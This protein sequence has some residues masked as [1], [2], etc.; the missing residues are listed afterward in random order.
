[1]RASVPCPHCGAL[2]PVGKRLCKACGRAMDA[3]VIEADVKQADKVK[4]DVSDV[5]RA[6]RYAAP[7]IAL[8]AVAVIAIGAGGYAVY[9][10]F[11]L[12][13]LSADQRLLA[14]VY[15]DPPYFS[16]TFDQDKGEN[17]SK[18]NRR[19]VWV[20]P[21]KKASFVFLNG[22][23]RFSSEVRSLE[24]DMSKATSLRAG[25]F[26]ETL[27]L[28]ELSKVAGGKPVRTMNVSKDTL[29]D[30]VW[31]EFSNGINALF[32]QGRLLMVQTVPTRQ[33]K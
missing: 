12:A 13:N 9:K 23:Y 15:G 19:E 22:A 3:K 6:R 30:A 2:V 18:L 33:G 5:S 24:P 14:K 7:L 16:V 1:M 28:D 26:S 21:E 25:Q 32:S 11:H 4:K 8:T 29:P 27:S 17:P 31:Y 20:Y 10:F